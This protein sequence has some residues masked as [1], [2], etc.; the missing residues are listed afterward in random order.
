MM[1]CTVNAFYPVTRNSLWENRTADPLGY[2]NLSFPKTGTCNYHTVQYY[3]DYTFPGAANYTYSSGS[4][5]SKGLL[6]RR[7]TLVLDI[8]SSR[9]MAVNYY[10]EEG[11]VAKVYKQHYQSGAIAV[12]NYDEV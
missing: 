12:G 1:I 3:D 10:D 5:K 2:S 6:T 9:L 8:T 7:L 4:L 11:R